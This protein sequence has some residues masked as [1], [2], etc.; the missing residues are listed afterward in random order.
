MKTLLPSLCFFLCS[1]L[2]L[3]AEE[4][5]KPALEGLWVQ[6]QSGGVLE[7]RT[8][9]KLAGWPVNGTYEVKEGNVL[10][11]KSG[12]ENFVCKYVVKSA[13]IMEL[14]RYVDGHDEKTELLRLKP[15]K[16]DLKV[17]KGPY[18]IRHMVAGEKRATER[19]VRLEESGHFRTKEGGYYLRVVPG[20]GPAPVLGYAQG[21]DDGTVAVQLFTAAE[22]LVLFTRLD[23]P[24]LLAVCRR[25]VE[26]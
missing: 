23:E 1:L 7:F 22:Y 2:T 19:A 25:V 11:M 9:G 21:D 13:D 26:K 5:P 15:A 12:G 14:T 17:M 8:G 4:P 6:R 3:R 18:F 24:T 16:L 20:T 10:D